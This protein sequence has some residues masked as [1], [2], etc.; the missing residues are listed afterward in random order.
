[1]MKNLCL[2][3]RHTTFFGCFSA[4]LILL[5]RKARYTSK[6]KRFRKELLR[7]LL[8]SDSDF[9]SDEMIRTRLWEKFGVA[10]SRRSVANLR[11]ELRLPASGRGTSGGKKR[12]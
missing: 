11:K 6:P 9:S 12:R 1:M 2:S 5:P 7:Q 4:F 8:E 3:R 10:I